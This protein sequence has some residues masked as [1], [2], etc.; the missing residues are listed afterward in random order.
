VILKKKIEDDGARN[1]FKTG[2]HA[3]VSRRSGIGGGSI[4]FAV[5]ALEWSQRS[6]EGLDKVRRVGDGAIIPSLDFWIYGVRD[7]EVLR[8]R[9]NITI[10]EFLKS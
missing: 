9:L 4:V 10:S 6:A 5:V 3:S 7:F 2:S 1:R 8:A